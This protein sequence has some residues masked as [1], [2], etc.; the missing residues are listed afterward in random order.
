MFPLKTD[1]PVTKKTFGV[2][3]LIIANFAVYIYFCI[4]YHGLL[5]ADHGFMPLKLSMPSDI[6]GIDEK[7]ASFFTYMFLHSSFFHVFI[8]M[9][10]LYIFGRNVECRLGTL[11]FLCT[12]IVIGILAVIV[13]AF[14]MPDL[15]YPV[16]GASGAVTGIMGM[17]IVFFPFAKIKTFIFLI[18]YAI[19]R[20]IPAIIIVML[21]FIFQLLVWYM[22]QTYNLNEYLRSFQ[23]NIGIRSRYL[24]ISNVA[25]YT[26]IGGFLSG[27]ILAIIIRIKRKVKGK[28]D[29]CA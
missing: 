14:M 11:K 8:N 5:F 2:W 1:I 22:E 6:V 23:E 12:Y 26:H 10:F 3:F 24:N 16:I 25:Y 7:M 4:N 28:E 27:I 29:L 15:E 13:E 21:F 19:I 9:Y 18:I 20:N 17:F